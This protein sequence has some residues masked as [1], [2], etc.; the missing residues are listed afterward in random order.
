MNAP[1]IENQTVLAP[2]VAAQSR[3][4]FDPSL[5]ESVVTRALTAGV[6]GPAGFDQSA[7]HSEADLLYGC[8]DG[9]QR[10]ANFRELFARWFY[11][12]Q[13]DHPFA[14]ALAELPELDRRANMITVTCANSR[15]DERADLANAAESPLHAGA[16]RFWLGISIQPARFL[17]RPLLRRWLRHELWHVRDM[18]D[19]AFQYTRQD[20]ASGAERLP[21][22]VVQDRFATLWSLSI[23]AR[24]ERAGL[25][26]LNSRQERLARI[27]GTLPGYRATA[28]QSVIDGIGTACGRTYPELA[29]FA[30]RPREL[31]GAESSDPLKQ[32]QPL[33]GSPCP[34][35]HFPTFHW[36]DLRPENT[37]PV[38]T[39]IRDAY[40]SWN[41]SSGVCATCFDLFSIRLGHWA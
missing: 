39:A 19:P 9:D 3:L 11:R 25:L 38:V 16:H 33:R 10:A 1:A 31:F 23:D 32:A 21:Q 4:Q 26:P 6:P 40:P 36:A 5:M 15:A 2:A 27:S 30:R 17:D 20:L 14:D 34:L 37:Q 22:R 12:G 35:C 29:Q 7:F 41:F 24:V 28:Y 18:L 8:A 13:F